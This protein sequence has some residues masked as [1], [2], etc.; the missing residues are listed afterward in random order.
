MFG[1]N[2]WG[3]QEKRKSCLMVIWSLL[4]YY[5][6]TNEMLENYFGYFDYH[7]LLLLLSVDFFI[8]EK[9]LTK[10]IFDVVV[11]HSTKFHLSLESPQSPFVCETELKI[12]FHLKRF[13]EFARNFCIM[14][15][16]LL[17]EASE[18]SLFARFISRLDN[19][20]SLWYLILK[21]SFSYFP[22]VTSQRRLIIIFREQYLCKKETI[23]LDED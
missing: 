16:L 13:R 6:W 10:M 23:S 19:I 11:I 15:F 14:S 8:L 9:I 12:S 1:G 5:E 20:F 4:I 18:F 3:E 7:L 17:T 21:L 2:F 22:H